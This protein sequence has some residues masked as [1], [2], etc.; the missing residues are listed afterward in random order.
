MAELKEKLQLSESQKGIDTALLISEHLSQKIDLEKKFLGYYQESTQRCA[1]LV[2][3]SA[4]L[5]LLLR[6]A[7]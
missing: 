2:V 3:Y 5:L 4:L 1:L 6:L 7:H